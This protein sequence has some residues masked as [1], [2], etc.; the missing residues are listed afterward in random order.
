MDHEEQLQ[1]H[2]YQVRPYVPRSFAHPEGYKLCR[3]EMERRGLPDFTGWLFVTNTV[4]RERYSSPHEA[5]EDIKGKLKDGIKK[6][7]YHGYKVKRWV[8]AMEF[9]EDDE[10]WPHWHW[11]LDERR[12]IPWQ[13]LNKC[14]PW[15]YTDIER[16]KDGGAV[17]GYMF[18]YITKSGTLPDWIL[19]NYKRIRFIQTSGVFE[20]DVQV[21]V[22]S[23][24]DAGYSALDDADKVEEP[25]LR[26]K[27]RRWDMKAIIVQER[28]N[29]KPI[30]RT[31]KLN[32]SYLDMWLIMRQIEEVPA[33]WQN[34]YL[35]RPDHIG[36][37]I[38][39]EDEV[40][41]GRATY[42]LTP[43]GH[44]QKRK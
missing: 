11:V 7:R 20:S 13:L 34:I 10:G 2:P 27:I 24:Q 40:S 5:Y 25:V 23:E 32:C 30:V 18:K 16:I 21:F 35:E 43:D 37:F 6:L 29:E 4:D 12:F 15:G 26:E 17:A 38:E 41:F 3:K 8:R 19:D 39:Q 22:D 9:H 31:I 44:I 28:P 1:S 14:F 42:V 36:Q 33:Y